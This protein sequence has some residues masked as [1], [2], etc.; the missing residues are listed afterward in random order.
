VASRTNQA[1]VSLPPA[2]AK[3]VRTIF[4]IEHQKNIIK[5]VFFVLL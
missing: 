3:N 2:A 1:G 5:V 4:R